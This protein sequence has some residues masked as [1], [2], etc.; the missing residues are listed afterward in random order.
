MKPDHSRAQPSHEPDPGPRRGNRRRETLR[1]LGTY[2]IWQLP[3]WGLVALALVWL[4]HALGLAAWRAAGVF[5]GFVVK[6]LLLFPAMRAVFSSMPSS[7]QPIGMFGETVEPLSP[8]GYIRV[9]GELWKAKSLQGSHVPT[10]TPVIVRDADGLT[11]IVEE[12]EEH[13]STKC[14]PRETP[15][16]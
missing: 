16:H 12:A 7:S 9:N 2:L 11:L 6:D 15:A 14:L 10:G 3:E 5:C 4:T 8:W 1:Q 13:A